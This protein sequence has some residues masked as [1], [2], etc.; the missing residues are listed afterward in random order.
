MSDGDEQIAGQIKAAVASLNE[1][2]GVAVQNGLLVTFKVIHLSTMSD[3][4]VPV[5]TARVSRPL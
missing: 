4:D 3:E 5:V 2:I 1:A